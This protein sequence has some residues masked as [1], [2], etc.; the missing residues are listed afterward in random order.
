MPQFGT[1]RPFGISSRLRAMNRLPITPVVW[2][3]IAVVLTAAV[4]LPPAS[5]EAAGR[6]INVTSDSEPGWIPSEEL[7]RSARQTVQ[8]YF[9]AVDSGNYPKAYEMMSDGNKAFVSSGQFDAQSADFH[10]RAGA[11]VSRNFLKA[12]WTKDP[13]NAPYPG[14]YVAIDVATRF[15]KIDR[16]CG[17]LVLYQAP[18]GGDFQIMRVESNFIDNATAQAIESSRSRAELDKTWAAVSANCPNFPE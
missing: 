16:H 9:A 12:T 4:L 5:A 17:Y 1:L 15:E 14:V 10:A 7:D 11:V 8:R 13:Q 2:F 18:S 3:A 6:E